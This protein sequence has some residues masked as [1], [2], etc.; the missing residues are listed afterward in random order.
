MSDE[1]RTPRYKREIEPRLNEIAEWCN[2]GAIDT[3]IAKRLGISIQTL[4][5]Y[6]RYFE[7]AEVLKKSKGNADYKVENSLFKRAMGYTYT[8]TEETINADGEVV[9]IKKV[10]KQVAPDTTA[11]I[12][13]LKNRMKENWS[14]RHQVE[15]RPEIF[16][17]FQ[18]IDGLADDSNQ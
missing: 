8:E 1:H 7:F 13:W 11:Q 15:V 5:D 14:D 2:E 4:Y 16:K 17:L 6:K 12:F 3:E 10:K 18:S 9:K